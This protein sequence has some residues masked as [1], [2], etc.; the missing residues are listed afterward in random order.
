MKTMIQKLAIVILGLA[1]SPLAHAYIFDDCAVRPW[2]GIDLQGRHIGM[3]HDFGGNIFKKDIVQY[4]VYGGVRI[5]DYLGLV[6]GF[7]ETENLGRNVGL[8]P[9]AVYLGVPLDA[10]EYH[11]TQTKIKGFY[12]DLMA[13]FPI[14]PQYCL[15]FFVSGGV[16]RNTLQLA[17][18]LTSDNGIIEPTPLVRTYRETSTGAR[19]SLGLQTIFCEHVGLRAIVSWENT[20]RFNNVKPTERP[21]A[22]TNVNIKDSFIYGLGIFITT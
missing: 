3:D 2:M 9:G 21:D 19:A 11:E 5:L 16:V 13:F 4:N 17:D 12:V 7:E 1:L 10:P 8:A 6:V 18:H 14:C 15:D 20:S 22:D